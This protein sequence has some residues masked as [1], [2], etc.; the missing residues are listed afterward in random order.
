MKSACSEQ[1]L[2]EIAGKCLEFEHIIN[3]MGYGYSLLNVSPNDFVR[4]CSDCVNWFGGEC[5]IYQHESK[6]TNILLES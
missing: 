2:R 4:R 3:A 5:V 1:R 6:K